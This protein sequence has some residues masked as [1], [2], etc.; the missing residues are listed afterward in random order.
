MGEIFG[1]WIQHIRGESF[2]V[3][4]TAVAG[5]AMFVENIPAGF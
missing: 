1:R 4:F 3:T 5:F 2:A